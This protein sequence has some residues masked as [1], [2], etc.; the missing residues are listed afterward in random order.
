MNAPIKLAALFAGALLVLAQTSG[1]AEAGHGHKSG[2]TAAKQSLAVQVWDQNRTQK[3]GKAYGKRG[4]YGNYAY[5]HGKAYG[6]RGHYGNYAYKHGKAYGKRGHY[7]NYAYK[8]GKSYGRRGH[9]GNYAYKHGK[10]YG[11]RGH[12]NTNPSISHWRY[13][14][15]RQQR[16]FQHRG[17]TYLERSY[18]N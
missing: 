14:A 16:Q 8:H 18:G 11:R 3:R 10:S 6:K 1:T 13:H 17:Q 5:R 4:H 2:Q 9:Y 12:Y 7:G 15:Q